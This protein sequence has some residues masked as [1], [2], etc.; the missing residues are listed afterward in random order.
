M[1]QY[2]VRQGY[3]S[4]INDTQKNRPGPKNVDY[5]TWEQTTSRVMYW[6]ATYVHDHMLSHIRDAKTPKEAWENLKKIFATNTTA[7]K[8]QLRQ[9]LNNIQQK[10]VSVIDYTTKIKD[11]CNSLDSINT[12]IDEDEM[13]QVC[14]GGLTQQ[15]DPLRMTILARENPPLFFNL[16]SMILVEENHVQTKSKTS[17]G[18]M[19]FSNLDGS[20]GRGRGGRRGR[21][22]PSHE[23]NSNLRQEDRSHRGTFGRRGSLHAKQGWKTMPLTYNYYGKIDHREEEC[24][25]KRSESASTV[26][27]SQTTPPTLNTPTVVDYS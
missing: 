17:E 2:L 22:G 25:K 13:V 7:H 8:L 18:K 21:F 16:Q 19:F 14:L 12:N 10:G 5:S 9:E 3:W 1:T 4:Y 26:D 24:R 20:R 27:N 11:I 6:L 23:G 15:F